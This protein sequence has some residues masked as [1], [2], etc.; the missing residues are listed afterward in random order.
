MT[1]YQLR[2][3]ALGQAALGNRPPHVAIMAVAKQIPKV[4]DADHSVVHSAS[5]AYV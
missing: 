3:G 2:E 4:A 5:S 1:N